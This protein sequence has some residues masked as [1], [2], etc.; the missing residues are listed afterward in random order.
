MCTHTQCLLEVPE[1]AVKELKGSNT[2]SAGT[3][4]TWLMCLSLSMIWLMTGSG[5]LLLLD[6]EPGC[7][8][9]GPANLTGQKGKAWSV[10]VA[11]FIGDFISREP[12]ELS[13]APSLQAR[14][15]LPSSVEKGN[16]MIQVQG[17]GEENG[18]FISTLNKRDT[19]TMNDAFFLIFF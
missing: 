13:F 15:L 10:T 12:Q 5:G 18:K 14:C 16:Y 19:Y 6:S 4:L 3:R 7:D 9:F 17:A 1:P 2:V 8:L 11:D